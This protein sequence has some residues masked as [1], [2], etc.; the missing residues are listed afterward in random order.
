MYNETL[1][2]QHDLPSL[3]P[4]C[5]DFCLR[6][7]HPPIKSES[8]SYESQARLKF[9]TVKKESTPQNTMSPR[10]P[11]SERQSIKHFKRSTE[12]PVP[13]L[14]KM[15][16]TRLAVKFADL[17]PSVQKRRAA[18]PIGHTRSTNSKIKQDP[19]NENDK[20]LSPRMM[21]QHKASIKKHSRCPSDI[22]AQVI[23]HYIDMYF[24]NINACG[25]QGPQHEG[26]L[27]WFDTAKAKSPDSL[28]IVHAMLAVGTTFSSRPER[29][30][31]GILFS[32]IT[33]R[34]MEEHPDGQCAQVAQT[35]L[36]LAL[37]YMASGFA[38]PA[39]DLAAS[40]LPAAL[41]ASLEDG[42][43]KKAKWLG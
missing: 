22:D 5:T 42:Y 3:A 11:P 20:M 23:N 14:A 33:R 21:D 17:S 16:A 38:G 30:A 12:S 2:H 28:M 19:Q 43:E 7:R 6:L 29:E 9:V 13:Q 36:M 8:P 4:R 32:G 25:S 37:Y 35:R 27:H 41:S 10:V 18:S 1:H 24:T 39:W 31:D 40:E 34:A 15:D 26:F